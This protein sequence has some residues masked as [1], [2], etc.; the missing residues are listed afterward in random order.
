MPGTMNTQ[1][2]SSRNLYSR[3]GTK[4][5]IYKDWLCLQR[6]ETAISLQ[7]WIDLEKNSAKVSSGSFLNT[8]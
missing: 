3:E 2:L 1:Q 8:K 4:G 5:I 7:S 6:E